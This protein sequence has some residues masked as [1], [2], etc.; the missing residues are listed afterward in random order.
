MPAQTVT[1]I[2][3]RIRIGFMLQQQINDQ[4]MPLLSGLMQRCIADVCAFF[5]GSIIFQQISDHADLTEMCSWNW[6]KG[7][8]QM[9]NHNTHLSGKET[10]QHAEE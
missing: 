9:K 5:H 8:E 6:T 7:W 1:Y 4:C 10:Y 2:C 3:D